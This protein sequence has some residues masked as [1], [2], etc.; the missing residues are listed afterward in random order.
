MLKLIKQEKDFI[1]KN[2]VYKI[3]EVEYARLIAEYIK[4]QVAPAQQAAYAEATR[5]EAMLVSEYCKDPSNVD[6]NSM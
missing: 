1:E 3:N 5:Q 2:A 6:Y 4:E